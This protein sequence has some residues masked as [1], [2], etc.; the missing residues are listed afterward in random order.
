MLHVHSLDSQLLAVTESK[1][2]VSERAQYDGRVHYVLLK[3]QESNIQTL[4]PHQHSI[5]CE[6]R[7]K[8][9]RMWEADKSSAAPPGNDHSNTKGQECGCVLNQHLLCSPN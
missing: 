3:A 9:V 1:A 6:T 4:K 5:L 2:V 8:K 7:T